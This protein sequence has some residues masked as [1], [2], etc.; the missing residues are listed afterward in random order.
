MPKRV[1]IVGVGMTNFSKPGLPTTPSY[2]ELA[3]QAI[4][5]AVNDI[6]GAVCFSDVQ[7]AVVGYTNTTGTGGGQRAVYSVGMTG[8]PIYN[9]NNACATGSSALF[10]GKQL[11][12]GGTA[13][14]VLAV[15]FEKM[16]KGPLQITDPAATDSPLHNHLAAMQTKFPLNTQGPLTPQLFANAAKEHM[17]KYNSTEAQLHKIAVKNH[18]HSSNNPYAQFTNIVTE[19]QVRSSRMITYPL[20]QLTCCPTS[21]GAA[22]VL[23]ASEDF[24]ISHNLQGQAVEILGMTMQ[25]DPSTSFQHSVDDTCIRMVGSR[26]A[27]NAA[28]ELYKMTGKGPE[29]VQVIELHDC[30]AA[31]EMLTYEA[32]GLCPEGAGGKL[33]ESGDVTYGGRWV[34]NP[35]GG[36]LSKGHPLGATGIA[37]CIEICWQL[38]GEAGPRQVPEAKVGLTHN[39]GLGGAC[40]V[41]MYQ[42]HEDWSATPK[43][44]KVSG[45][46]GFNRTQQGLPRL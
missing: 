15:G 21:D 42:L 39:L 20:T 27:E 38:R 31:N 4:E 5:R 23:L 8:I 6:G 26:M 25:T 22:A 1:F 45:A 36:L 3:K 40:V 17:K 16:N 44:C 14:C 34:V 18:Q 33:V 41:G 19:E 43:A 29:D 46:M 30:F 32:L 28:A 37:Q 9:V 10:L 11:V 24:V 2:H 12:E 7:Q 13:S 35:S